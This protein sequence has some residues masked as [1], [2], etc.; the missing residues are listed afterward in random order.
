MRDEERDV[1]PFVGELD[2][3]VH[4]ESLR[5]WL[6]G[7]VKAV[8]IEMLDFSGELDAHEEEAEFG[9]LML[10]GVQDVDVVLLH[11]KRHDGGDEAFAV[12]AVDEEGGGLGDGHWAVYESWG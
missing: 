5:S 8:L 10:I 1:L 6:K 11:K 3:P 7:G 12:G 9:V 2:P 4:A